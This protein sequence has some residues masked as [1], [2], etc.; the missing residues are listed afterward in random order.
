MNIR[1]IL[2][3]ADNICE[4]LFV[5]LSSGFIESPFEYAKIMGQSQQQWHLQTVYRGLGLQLMRTTALLLPIFTAL[6]VIRR[7]TDFLKT[8]HGNFITTLTVVGLSYVL[9]W[10]FETLKNLAQS[11]VPRPH[12]THA[13]RIAFLGGYKGLVRGVWPGAIGGGTRNAFGMVAMVYAQQWS[14]QLGLR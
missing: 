2:W 14:T 5:F 8:L 6:D 9:T 4:C 11:G 3:L 1:H 13:E 12:A 10:P 7:K